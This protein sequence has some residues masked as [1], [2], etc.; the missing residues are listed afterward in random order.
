MI[1]ADEVE[2]TIDLQ[3]GIA[4]AQIWYLEGRPVF[5]TE[6]SDITP[7]VDLATFRIEPPPGTR[8]IT[9][10]LLAEAGL[11]PA[12]QPGRPPRHGAA[13]HG[14]REALGQETTP[15]TRAGH[16]HAAGSVMRAAG[17]VNANV[18]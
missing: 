15:L 7:D 2:V 11:S 3:L 18:D 13:G 17:T 8:V 12:E 14:D 6:L 10:G 16:D 1:A 9:G 4:L 5:R